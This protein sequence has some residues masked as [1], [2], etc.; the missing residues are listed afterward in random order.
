[1]GRAS[2]RGGKDS[3]GLKTSR[4]LASILPIPLYRVLTGSAIPVFSNTNVSNPS[5]VVSVISIRDPSSLWLKEASSGLLPLIINGTQWNS[6]AVPVLEDD[7][8]SSW[9]GVL[10]SGGDAVLLLADVIAPDGQVAQTS[11]GIPL[12]SG[13]EIGVSSPTSSQ[14]GGLFLD[15]TATFISLMS[16]LILQK[17]I[18]VGYGPR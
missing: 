18:E 4:E 11:S 15:D 6:V 1:M 5:R 7:R 2:Y 9:R 13:L 8:V 3:L 16:E 12:V 14:T 17:A 10:K